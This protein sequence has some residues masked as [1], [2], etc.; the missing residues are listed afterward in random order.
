M[1]YCTY[2]STHPS[3]WFY[4]GKG[5]TAAVLSGKYKG[6]GVLIKQLFKKYPKNE[7][8]TT[9]LQTFDTES[10]AY[11]AEAELVTE[12]F[13]SQEKCA[14]LDTGGLHSTRHE[15]SKRLISESLK[16][17]RALEDKT[18]VK[19]KYI[20]VQNRPDVKTK[21]SEGIRAGKASVEHRRLMSVRSIEVGSR[22]EILESR[23]KHSLAMWQDP[24]KREQI[25]LSRAGKCRAW[26][27][28]SA[29]NVEYRSM[30]AAC[31]ETGLTKALLKHLPSFREIV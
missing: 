9:I 10:A 28:V 19:D 26:V 23:K 1:T 13:V 20:A 16:K 27:R 8:A 29:N 7:W 11:L 22:P 3:G 15:S 4:A 5:T 24:V 12:D 14:N 6:S 25:L 21:K 30:T 31:K 17:T 2:L 18:V